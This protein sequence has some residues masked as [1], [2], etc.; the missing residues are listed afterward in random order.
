M[1]PLARCARS[2]VG[3]P[4][5][6]ARVR[7]APVSGLLVRCS[8]F[9]LPAGWLRSGALPPGPPVRPAAPLGRV[10]GRAPGGPFL[11]AARQLR[12]WAAC[13]PARGVLPL[14]APAARG[15]CARFLSLPRS[16]RS[17]PPPASGRGP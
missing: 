15:S 13:R 8:A 12:R 6:G 5:C 4:S 3:A 1:M 2:L 17:L 14:S 7:C 16:L 11:P 9:R 10:R